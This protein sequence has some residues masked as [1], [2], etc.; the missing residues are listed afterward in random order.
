MAQWTFIDPNTLLPGD[1]WTSAKAQAAFENLEAVAEGADGAPR[2]YGKAAVPR[3]Q[4]AELGVL[5]VDVGTI[6]A[7][8]LHWQG[9]FPASFITTSSSFQLA[10][11]IVNV[12]FSGNARF[13]AIHDGINNS[14]NRVRFVKNGVVVQTFSKSS[15]DSE[16]RTVDVSISPNDVFRWEVQHDVSSGGASISDMV[17]LVSDQYVRIGIPIR[18]SDL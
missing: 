15:S 14:G 10:G 3:T 8:N 13:R 16:T 6:E 2:L 12:L 4:Q 5:A 17:V 9:D 1:P 18:E 7:N 11:E